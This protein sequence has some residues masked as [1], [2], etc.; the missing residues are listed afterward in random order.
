MRKP[1]PT[2]TKRAKIVQHA[3]EWK[4]DITKISS[5]LLNQFKKK[6]MN[7]PLKMKMMC[8]IPSIS[9]NMK[10]DMRNVIVNKKCKGMWNK[11]KKKEE[12][13]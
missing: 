9:M 10:M 6:K 4:W 11:W 12:K 2:Q 1:I 7:M 8:L 13:W 5:H 3:M